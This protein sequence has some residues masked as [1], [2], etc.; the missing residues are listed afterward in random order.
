MYA[1][2]TKRFGRYCFYFSR[3]RLRD[4]YV[5]PIMHFYNKN[6]SELREYCYFIC[7]SFKDNI[8]IRYLDIISDNNS[9]CTLQSCQWLTLNTFNHHG[10]FQGRR[11][12]ASLESFALY[13][14]ST[15]LFW[16]TRPVPSSALLMPYSN[17]HGQ[18]Y[19]VSTR[20]CRVIVALHLGQLPGLWRSVVLHQHCLTT[21]QVKITIK[22]QNY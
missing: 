13:F 6:I 4:V 21:E 17:I 3:Y 11:T 18:D 15:R 5:H 2:Y 14:R 16:K 20:G 9:C 22:M 10:P 12:S 19:L 1:K 7:F 8:Y